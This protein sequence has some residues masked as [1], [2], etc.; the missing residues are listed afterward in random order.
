M[1][2]LLTLAL[3]ATAMAIISGVLVSSIETRDR[4]EESIVRYEVGPAVLR[5]MAE[6]IRAAF[7]PF[8]SPADKEYFVGR[9]I[10]SGMGSAD[11]LDFVST[12]NSFD[13]DT[14][15][16]CDVTEIGYQMLMN[17]EDSSL[18]RLMRRE[19]PFIDDKPLSGGALAQ[20]FNRVKSLKFEYFDGE[21]WKLGWNNTK[22]SAKLP[23]AVRIELILSL[24]QLGGTDESEPYEP[25]FS[26]TVSLPK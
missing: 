26:T 20:M 7:I 12:R 3:L 9:A 2:V 1:E 25:T 24:P 14:G 6:D 23:E 13:P 18:Y 21:E 11:R 16:E 4:I 17:F 5:I 15:L 22:Q 19:D 10:T 8:G